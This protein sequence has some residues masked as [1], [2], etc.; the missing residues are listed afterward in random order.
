M[1]DPGP[2]EFGTLTEHSFID[3]YARVA[4]ERLSGQLVVSS[5]TGDWIAYFKSGTPVRIDSHDAT[6]ALSAFLVKHD[7]A[8][9]DEVERALEIT[10]GDIN[11]LLEALVSLELVAAQDLFVLLGEFANGQLQRFFALEDGDFFWD[12]TKSAPQPAF[13]LGPRW[14]LL[15]RAVRS[16]PPGVVRRRLGERGRQAVYRSSN[17]SVRT[18]DLGLNAPETRVLQHFNGTRSPELIARELPGEREVVMRLALLLG[19]TGCVSF[20]P[21]LGLGD[22]AA[23][24]ADDDAPAMEKRSAFE[25]SP[26]SPRPTPASNVNIGRVAVKSV[27]VRKPAAPAARPVASP[28][29]KQPAAKPAAASPPPRPQAPKDRDSLAAL[30]KKWQESDFFE[31]LG[32]P[33]TA[34][35]E[36]IKEAFFGLAR[37]YHPDT[38]TDRNNAELTGLHADLTS[39]LNEAYG[40]LE[41]DA[42]RA[43]YLDALANGGAETVDVGPIFQAEEDFLRATIL[44]KAR[45]YADAVALLDSAIAVLPNEADFIAWRAWARFGASKNKRADYEQCV[46]ECAEAV[47]L[48]Q[49]CAVGHL[50]IGQMSKLVG[51]RKRAEKAFKAVLKIEPDNIEARRELRLFA[52]RS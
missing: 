44:V 49:H 9:P 17:S 43:S 15:S 25:P 32:V 14:Q 47:K 40:T 18:D 33:R 24:M 23:P 46:T 34:K 36:A 13:P 26:P 8:T 45:K 48:S 42:S 7:K 12:A 10:G 41:N 27:A 31:I 11:E 28:T 52:S 5:E 19:D 22:A 1:E 2:P 29:T 20:G 6:S 3:L 50:F 16:L 51:D 38:A 39:I 35:K 4:A 30:L 37:Q 21:E